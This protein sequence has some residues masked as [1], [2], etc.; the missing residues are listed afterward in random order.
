MTN[1]RGVWADHA[2]WSD[3]WTV[4]EQ[5]P[6]G[7]QGDAW[8]VLS[9]KNGPERFLK[10]IRAKR[11]PERRARFF[12]EASAYDTINGN[13]I[14]HLVESNAHRH[15]DS[16]IEPY[17]VTEFIE[18]LTLRDW[19]ESQV[20]VELRE[21]I[22]VTRDLLETLS[23]CH[24]ARFV[25]RDVKPDNIILADGEPR[26]PVLVDFGLNFREGPEID[27]ETELGQEIGN[28]FLRL[29]EL[30]A[31]SFL[32]QDSRSDLT[33]A[34]GIF[35]YLLTGRHPGILQDEEGRLPHQRTES[36]AILQ[37]VAGAVLPRL[38]SFFDQAFEPHIAH[39]FADAGAILER[40]ERLMEPQT[41]A[42]SEEA[43]RRDIRDAM[44]TRAAR[45]QEESHGRLSEALRQFQRLHDEVR[46]SLK[47]DGV[48]LNRT[49]TNC[50]V[51]GGTGRNTLGWVRPGSEDNVLSVEC[52]V[53]EAGDEIVVYLSEEPVYRTPIASPRYDEKFDERIRRWLL[54]QLH[55]LVAGPDNTSL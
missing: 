45:R 5:I 15:R 2:R 37:E 30:S 7:G 23:K 48:V 19:R 53:R 36:Y 28:R 38:A 43:L 20:R 16:E 51:I 42:D 46:E 13:G 47:N 9:K 44:D 40:M 26:R 55:E 29:P 12:R 33:F 25:H 49:Q 32:K 52:L 54:Q 3:N 14:P 10:A 8:R 34:A 22:G 35:F 1:Q 4:V 27:F 21:A 39:R 31:G 6:G 11:D 50:N 18:G 17:I 41:A 24:A